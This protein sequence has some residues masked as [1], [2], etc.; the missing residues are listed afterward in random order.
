MD[1]GGRSHGILQ[2]AG[3]RPLA[4]VAVLGERREVG[5][6]AGRHSLG[7]RGCVLKDASTAA[8]KAPWGSNPN[9]NR[10]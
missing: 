7:T 4:V 2:S 10:H 8:D 9:C 3:C 6:Q 1:H 5:E